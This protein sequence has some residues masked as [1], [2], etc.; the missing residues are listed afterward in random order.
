MSDSLPKVNTQ[1]NNDVLPIIVVGAGP[2]GFRFIQEL[3]KNESQTPVILFGNEPYQPYDRVRL[4]S[5]LAGQ[6]SS[7]SLLLPLDELEADPNFSY[8]YKDIVAINPDRKT[9]ADSEG[10]EYSYSKLILATGSRA[11][12]PHIPGVDLDG[13]FTFRNM[14]DAEKLKARTTRCKDLVVVGGGLLGLEAARAMQG[15]QTNI[16]LVQQAS[17]IMNQQLDDIAASSLQEKL[18]EL[19]IRIV[20]GEG[21][22]G[23]V[24]EQRVEGVALRNG[25]ILDCDTV[26]ISAGIKPNIDLARKSWIKVGSGIRVNDH[27]QTSNPDIYA[28]GECAEHKEKVYGLVAPGFEQAAV[29]ADHIC[30]GSSQYLGSYSV[31]RLKV[32][33]ETVFSMGDVHDDQ[34]HDPKTF[35]SFSGAEGNYR[36]LAFNRGQLVGAVSI[37]DWDETPR[38]QE[39]LTHKRKLKSWQKLRF[40]LTGNLWGSASN[41]PENWPETAVICNCNNVSRG[42][43]SSAIEQGCCS[44]ERIAQSTGA[45]STCGSCKPLVQQMLGNEIV[46]PAEPDRNSLLGT[47][48]AVLAALLAFVM[49]PAMT[50][51]ESVQDSLRLDLIWNDGLYKQVTGFTLLGLT[52][53]GMLMSLKKRSK[54]LRVGSFSFWRIL[55]AALASICLIILLV[56]TGFNAGQSLNQ[57]LL[58][59]FLMLAV[60]GAAVSVAIGM[61]YKLSP[62]IGRQVRNIGFWGHLLLS[63]PLP[64]L[65]SFHILSVYYF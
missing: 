56:H 65:L 40:R 20:V 61:Q 34:P 28:I 1:Q 24:G 50:V 15:N 54:V 64:A 8:L 5:L 44:M 25:E 2:V 37:G 12:V 31:A 62:S 13:V 51:S 43:L 14:R 60:L 19:G 22:K 26:L 59:N 39:L 18:E 27:L 49:V 32:V 52:I 42:E 17:R 45:T 11:H 7:E 63:W 57:W 9:V 35:L 53:L 33:G 30:K 10:T 29:A 16:T 38:I 36:K 48:L 47:S 3:R 23:V 4:S 55:H 41:S 21:V 58:L 6:S 46:Q